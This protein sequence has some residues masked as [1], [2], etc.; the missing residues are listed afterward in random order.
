MM[1]SYEKSFFFFFCIIWNWIGW[2][3]QKMQLAVTKPIKRCLYPANSDHGGVCSKPGQQLSEDRRPQALAFSLLCHLPCAAFLPHTAQLPRLHASCSSYRWKETDAGTGT[4][5][6]PCLLGKQKACLEGPPGK[7]PL[8]SRGPDP[9]HKVMPKD[10]EDW[11]TVGPGTWPF[12]TKSM[13][14]WPECVLPVAQ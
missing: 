12:C 3:Q 11:K 2:Q 10:K 6:C 4:K 7:V 13:S 8:V 9:H 5:F 14:C 1:A